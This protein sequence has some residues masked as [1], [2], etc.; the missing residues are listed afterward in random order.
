[1]STSVGRI[2]LN[3]DVDPGDFVAENER[4]G[5]RGGNALEK[6][7]ER[8]AA[9]MHT[10]ARK[11]LMDTSKV[12]KIAFGNIVA[13]ATQSITFG[14]AALVK[15]GL[16][17]MGTLQL[18]ERSME[19]FGYQGQEVE[20]V[21]KRLQDVAKKTPFEFPE[22]ADATR[23]IYAVS[24]AIWGTGQSLQQTEENVF[25]LVDSIG[26]LVATFGG[27]QA[28]FDNAVLA[29]S[30]M[31]SQGKIAAQEM[32]QL[33]D[34][35]PGFNAWRELAAGM[36][37]SEEQLR[38]LVKGGQVLSKDAL[39]V[40]LQRMKD[41]GPAA[42]AM[43]RASKT[44][45]GVLSNLKD[46]VS[47]ALA[48]AL[49]PFADALITLFNV[50]TG[51][52]IGPLEE[53]LTSFGKIAS[54]LLIAFAPAL[55]NSL[56]LFA[57]LGA[58][59]VKVVDWLAP[60]IPKIIEFADALKDDFIE[61]IRLW[62]ERLAGWWDALAGPREGLG[63]FVDGPLTSLVEWAEKVGLLTGGKDV[64]LDLAL[65]LGALKLA[66]VG[67]GIV[68][69][70]FQSVV[71]FWEPAAK[72][73][74]F[75][76]TK[77][78]WP[79]VTALWGLAATPVGLIVLAVAAMA[80][81]FALLYFHVK[82]FRNFIDSIFTDKLS[83]IL[84]VIL[85][86]TTGLGFA[87]FVLYKKVKPVR[88]A[89][90]WV[91]QS[92]QKLWD[93]ILGV[94]DAIFGTL[95]AAFGI[96]LTVWN[97]VWGAVGTVVRTVIA[98]I[99]D[100]WAQMGDEIG[101]V[102]GA[103]YNLVAAVFNRIWQTIRFYVDIITGLWDALFEI[104]R[105][106]WTEMTNVA[107]NLLGGFTEY[108]STIWNL[109]WGII[110]DTVEQVWAVIG[111]IIEDGLALASAAFDAFI[112]FVGPL[113]EVIWAFISSAVSIAVETVRNVVEGMLQVIAGVI[114]TVAAI[115]N[116]DW[117]GAWDSVSTIVEGAWNILKGILNGI[118]NFFRTTWDTV[119]DA[120]TKPFI[121][122]W[123]EIKKV[124]DK[125]KSFFGGII[126]SIKGVINGFID[127][128]NAIQIPGVTVGGMELPGPIPDIPSFSIGPWD[129][130][131]IPF[132]LAQGGLITT[133]TY[134]L[135]GE[136]GPEVVIP[137]S[138]P[139]RAQQL[140]QQAGLSDTTATGRA[141]VSIGTATF[142]TPTDLDLLFQKAEAAMVLT[143][144][145]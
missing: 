127:R 17:T 62:G 113:W 65:G 81:A 10:K 70:F 107:S 71:L 49:I 93:V 116:L 22:L 33:N 90:D 41:F 7:Y 34:A 12:A 104:W 145:I 1:M 54:S 20:R 44:I 96:I 86:L 42:G 140:M 101:M 40:L 112:A 100:L 78:I 2:V 30:Q 111:P 23:R 61:R 18:A 58:V 130:P 117:Q 24:E 141:I 4:I 84:G 91:W 60:I 31:G 45:T 5:V 43:E 80:G 109:L 52:L 136:A 131:N 89:V 85:Y 83:T 48:E 134:A 79:L 46:V 19:A 8:G 29:V 66:A 32:R 3:L 6:G 97:A 82:P 144:A 126:D 55:A 122:A 36:G 119:Y 129:F 57:E 103:I 98:V 16:D 115:I 123:D 13:Y 59:L 120:L 118:I 88:Q 138:K 35:L 135:V 77:A 106:V 63:G 139:A 74:A 128:F 50:D 142:V 64:L 92:L 102:I 143:G 26:N 99:T 15:F 137:L 110:E 67:I 73:I 11:G 114:D 37:I 125:A 39:P 69:G 133:P 124:W 27:T 95:Q 87:F 75:M 56:T 25:G 105:V 94:A 14:A 21:M 121:K 51:T 28:N 132:R 53:V 108:V 47:F 68:T 76:A 72:I 38:K 9:G